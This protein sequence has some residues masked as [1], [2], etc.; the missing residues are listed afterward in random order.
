MVLRNLEQ[1]VA[2]RTGHK[3]P[4]DEPVDNMITV[5]AIIKNIGYKRLNK[6]YY[7]PT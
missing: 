5:N 4:A 6:N 1:M 2:G 7:L 3:N